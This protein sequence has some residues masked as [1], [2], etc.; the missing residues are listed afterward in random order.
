MRVN[1]KSAI[2]K[3]KSQNYL[4]NSIF[5]PQCFVGLSGNYPIIYRKL[6][7]NK[8]QPT[9]LVLCDIDTSIPGVIHKD[10]YE[11]VKDHNPDFVDCDFCGTVITCGKV[12][13]KCFN[14][15][16]RNK[17]HFAISFT[18]STRAHGL[19]NEKSLKWINDNVL[20]NTLEIKDVI[21]KETIISLSI[22]SKTG[23]GFPKYIKYYNA[24]CVG[25]NIRITSYC[26]TSNMIS[27]IIWR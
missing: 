25:Y 5:T 27:G 3:R 8:L 16:N 9:K 12:F 4:F 19:G 15:L 17:K 18:F 10:I 6:I 21:E 22:K 20:N 11:V 7:K 13:Q 24:S 23:R 2:F 14:F 26:D 1:Y